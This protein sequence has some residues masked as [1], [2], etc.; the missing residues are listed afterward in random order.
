MNLNS[1]KFNS[2]SFDTIVFDCDGVILNSNKIKTQAFYKSALPYGHQAAQALVDYHVSNGGISRYKKFEYF[3]CNLTNANADGPGL[4]ALLDVYASEVRNGLLS[5]EVTG[6]LKE[7]RNK[8]R[9]AT[10]LI[11]S[12]GD[13]N[14]LREIF[15]K[16][17]LFDLFDGGIFGSPDSKDIILNREIKGNFKSCLYIGDSKY[18]YHVAHKIGIDFVF[19]SNWTEVENW[20]SWSK[21]LNIKTMGNVEDLYDAFLY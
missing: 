5:C 19:L 13:Q 2:K 8:T 9:H 12:G 1:L 16:R 21:T 18:D 20:A 10:W 14:E 3:L 15:I 6:M 7:F 17:G 4:D 11:A